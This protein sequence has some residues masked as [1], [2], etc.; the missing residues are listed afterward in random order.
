MKILSLTQGDTDNLG[1]KAIQTVIF[2]F[3]QQQ[4]CE[5][6]S[7]QFYPE[8]KRDISEKRKLYGNH[9]IKAEKK[10]ND[11]FNIKTRLKKVQWLYRCYKYIQIRRGS[12]QVIRNLNNY[13][14]NECRQEKF[15]LILIGGG[16]LI[17]H[18]HDFIYCM[19]FW[20]QRIKIP[21]IIISVGC[22]TALS[23]R[24]KKRY[25]NS[26]KFCQRIIVRDRITQKTI[27][28]LGLKCRLAP[29]A[30]FLFS[31]IFPNYC[32]LLREDFL[33]VEIYAYNTYYNQTK[34]EYYLQW[35]KLILESMC[36]KERIIFS[37]STFEDYL[38]SLEYMAFFKEK[39]KDL[40]VELAD[41]D[42][43][44]KLVHII[45]KARKIISGRMHVLILAMNFNKEIAVFEVSDKLK[46]FN[47]MYVEN[48]INLEEI[49]K[50]IEGQLIGILDFNYGGKN[51]LF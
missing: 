43:L 21:K 17:K 48:K 15:D 18:N 49:R 51:E 37:Y 25:Y 5:V 19:E 38:E 28:N 46:E 33:L 14:D 26:L 22:D 47:I 1:D 11:P 24:E 6:I 45:T 2:N 20:C 12:L 30:A 23:K 39:Y 8:E 9:N 16:Q 27:E 35:E 34:R 3:F 32:S 31:K 10:S 40:K 44:E 41:T 29:D 42:T 13:F 36:G 4:G 7:G 50:S